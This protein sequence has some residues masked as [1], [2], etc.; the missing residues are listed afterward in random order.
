MQV[1]PPADVKTEGKKT[2]G[3]VQNLLEKKVKTIL[4]KKFK[5]IVVISFKQNVKKS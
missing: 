5:K 4:K 1:M 2:C 3:N